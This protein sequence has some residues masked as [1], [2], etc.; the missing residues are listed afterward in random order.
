[1]LQ[2]IKICGRQRY[3]RFFKPQSLEFRFFCITLVSN[4]LYCRLKVDKR[5]EFFIGIVIYFWRVRQTL[6]LR[7]AR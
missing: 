7:W 5:P 1:M 3:F 2:K 6:A 4:R